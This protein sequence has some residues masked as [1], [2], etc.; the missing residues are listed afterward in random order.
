V[1]FWGVENREPALR[2]VATRSSGVPHAKV[3]LKPSDA[4]LGSEGIAGRS[5]SRSSARSSPVAARMP[6]R[7]PLEEIISAHLWRY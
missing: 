2:Y 4:L 5:A 1:A 6:N 3:E 7:R